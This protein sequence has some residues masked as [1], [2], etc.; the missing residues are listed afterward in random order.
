MLTQLNEKG[1]YTEVSDT[2]AEGE[3]TD[4]DTDEST[5]EGP[6]VESEAEIDGDAET[7]EEEDRYTDAT[8]AEII[9][10]EG[11]LFTDL[12]GIATINA[13]T[14][15]GYDV[16]DEYALTMQW[17]D[18]SRNS[19]QSE[20]KDSEG[21]DIVA[22]AGGETS[23]DGVTYTKYVVID[24]DD[25]YYLVRCEGIEDYENSTESEEGA[26]DSIKDNIRTEL[27]EEKA[28]AELEEKVAAEDSKFDVKKKKQDS[29]DKIVS[30][31]TW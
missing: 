8:I 1:T 20:Q 2:E 29:I 26:A 3:K 30:E 31:L 12:E 14:S 9:A 18:D 5:E 4:A 24:D 22:D 23:E 28:V 21:K 17:I 7:T 27:Y 15:S 6:V 25:Y 11:A 10:T 16:L 19:I 13:V